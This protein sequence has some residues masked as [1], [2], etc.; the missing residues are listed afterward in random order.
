MILTVIGVAFTAY[1][2]A[3]GLWWTG[4]V[5][6]PPLIIASIILY[7]TTTWLWIFWGA[8]SE[9][10]SAAARDVPI[11]AAVLAMIVAVAVP[12]ALMFATPVSG[13]YEPY[14]TWAIGGIG[15]LMT[16][17]M[18]R[19]RWILAWTGMVLMGGSYMF[20]LGPLEALVYGLIGSIVWVAVAQLALIF[21]VRAS[22]DAQKL[23]ELQQAASAWQAAHAG[24][25]QE[26][27]MHVR[28]ALAEAG[29]ILSRTIV[30]SGELTPEERAAA[31]LAEWRLRDEL[32]AARLLD[33]GVRDAVDDLRK[34][35]VNVM[36]LDEGGLDGL[37]DQALGAIRAELADIL[38]GATSPRLYVRTS[39]DETIAVTVVGRAPAPQGSGDEDAVELWRE[40]PHFRE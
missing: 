25:A 11:W 23:A 36:L 24:R 35:G 5:T 15:A 10:E 8:R 12:N 40:I 20:W 19:G 29:P 34:R 39:P 38:R 33:N 2:A 37:N 14:V 21:L 30:T 18:V 1:L 4:G 32:R 28:R 27:R 3:R 7:V 6:S 31:R 9:R 16:I 22:R 26:R 17:L 13:H